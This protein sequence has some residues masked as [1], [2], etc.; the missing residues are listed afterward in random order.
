MKAPQTDLTNRDVVLSKNLTLEPD[1]QF[2]DGNNT[3]SLSYAKWPYYQKGTTTTTFWLQ[4][5]LKI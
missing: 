3:E 1:V 4:E 2:Q 5:I